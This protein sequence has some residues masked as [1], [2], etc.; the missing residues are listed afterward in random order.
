VRPCCNLGALSRFAGAEQATGR[1][2]AQPG[3]MSVTGEGVRCEIHTCSGSAWAG[4]RSG[5]NPLL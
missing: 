4:S 1:A 5:L 3:N 2:F